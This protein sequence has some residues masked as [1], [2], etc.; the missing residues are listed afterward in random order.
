MFAGS[1]DG[2]LMTNPKYVS[3][4]GPPYLP[5]HTTRDQPIDLRMDMAAC[6]N[7]NA[8]PTRH[9]T[10]LAEHNACV[11]TL[12]VDRHPQ[13]KASLVKMLNDDIHHLI[14]AAT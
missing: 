14:E 1:I 2:L 13:T 7:L 3:S 10:T 11:A 6:D 5:V 8:D 12:R 9:N 4:F